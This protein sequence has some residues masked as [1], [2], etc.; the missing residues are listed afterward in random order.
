MKQ[1]VTGDVIRTVSVLNTVGAG[2]QVLVE[3]VKQKIVSSQQSA[4]GLDAALTLS[5]LCSQTHTVGKH[6]LWFQQSRSGD[7]IQIREWKWVPLGK[8]RT[9]GQNTASGGKSCK[10]RNADVFPHS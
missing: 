1:T 2:K 7:R 10:K 9:A 3:F 4:L 6:W 8:D 5:T